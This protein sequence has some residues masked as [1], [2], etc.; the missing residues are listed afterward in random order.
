MNVKIVYFVPQKWQKEHH[1]GKMLGQLFWHNIV[2]C[3]FLADWE[4]LN[5]ECA[6]VEDAIFV[7]FQNIWA[8]NH[9]NRDQV[10][11]FSSL[12]L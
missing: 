10:K 2:A 7:G 12:S 8:G 6:Y 1:G 3:I 4:I 11:Q 5:L 9:N